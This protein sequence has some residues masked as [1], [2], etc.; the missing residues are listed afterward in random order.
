MQKSEDHRSHQDTPSGNH[1]CLYKIFQSG[2]KKWKKRPNFQPLEALHALGTCI[3]APNFMAIQL[4]VD[5]TFQSQTNWWRYRKSQGNTK[6]I[7]IHPMATMHVCTK[8]HGNP[9]NS[10]CISV[11][12]KSSGPTDQPTDQPTNPNMFLRLHEFISCKEMG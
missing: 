11:W 4:L 8:F 7:G 1:E 5:T 3:S 2:P 10:C 6:V 9:T 12:K